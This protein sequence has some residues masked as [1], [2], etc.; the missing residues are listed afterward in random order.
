MVITGVFR[1][2]DEGTVRFR[3]ESRCCLTPTPDYICIYLQFHINALSC[4]FVSHQR[5]DPTA[6]FHV[7]VTPEGRC[8]GQ[9]VTAPRGSVCVPRHTMVRTAVAADL[10][11]GFTLMVKCFPN[12]CEDKFIVI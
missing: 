4:C 2:T 9:C 5:G 1:D 10:V 3:P 6:V 12:N 7:P 11:S 8:Q